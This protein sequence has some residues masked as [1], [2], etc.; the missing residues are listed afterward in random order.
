MLENIANSGA[1]AQ[2]GLIA[3]A[4]FTLGVEPHN[5]YRVSCD[6]R[7][8]GCDC[9]GCQTWRKYPSRLHYLCDIR[10]RKA[11]PAFDPFEVPNLTTT[12]G[13]NDQLTQYFKGAAY[14][15]AWF[16]GLVDNASWSAYAVG[17]TMASHAGWIE[18]NT[19]Y[20]QATR[21]AW[22]GGSVA[23]GSVDNSA[24]VAVFSMTGTITVRGAF[25][26][27][28]STK[29]GTLGILYGVADFA[30]ARSLLNGDTLNVT[31]TDTLT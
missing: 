22:T 13:K 16:V 3:K 26:N 10:C 6:R 20:S 15:A 5:F 23:A 25:Q 29:G 24:S 17:D 19:T 4:G 11:Y 12:V 1:D 31:I 21:P 2:A 27:S 18:T 30:A 9:K 14:T 28:V 7:P 8:E